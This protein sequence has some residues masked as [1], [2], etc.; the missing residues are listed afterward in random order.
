M[1]KRSSLSL[2]VVVWFTA[3]ASFSLPARAV[4]CDGNGD[5]L[6][7]L[8]DIAWLRSLIGPVSGVRIN[9]VRACVQQCT[10]GKCT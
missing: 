1:L 10:G 5:G 7:G 6:V 8:W 3:A 4:S 2:L 9:D